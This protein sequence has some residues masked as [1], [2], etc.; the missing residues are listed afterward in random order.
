[1]VKKIITS[2]LGKPIPLE[3][4]AILD[5]VDNSVDWSSASVFVLGGVRKSADGKLQFQIRKVS[6]VD[7]DLG[8]ELRKYI[9]KYS[10]FRFKFFRSTRYAFDKECQIYHQL[11]P[12]DNIKHPDRP[13]NT[14][15]LCSVADCISSN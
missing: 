6:H 12:V 5:E 1:M 2:G 13:I 14:K 4:T 15:F 7:G 8:K 10:G 3:A 11:K 9:G